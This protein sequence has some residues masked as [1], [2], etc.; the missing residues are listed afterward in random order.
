MTAPD[1][2]CAVV[3]AAGLGTRLR[4]LTTVL[5]KALAPVGNVPLLERALHRL[6]E[7]GLSGP[8]HVAVNAHH[9]ADK[10]ADL[11]GDRAHLSREPEPLGSAGALGL[12]KPW[13][14]DRAVL[15]LNA[16]AYVAAPAGDLR[17]LF[18]GWDGRTVRMLG[19][20]AEDGSPPFGGMSFAGASL[21]PPAEAAALNAEYSHLVLTTWRPAERTGRLQAIPLAGTYIDCGSPAAYL[22][23]N[24]HAAHGQNLVAPGAIVTGLALESVIGAGSRMNGTVRRC[25]LWPGAQ[26]DADELLIDSIRVGRDMTVEVTDA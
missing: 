19:R 22:A 11:V 13:I 18:D 6:S 25:V 23:A 21:I 26:V 24:M 4:P 15:V 14:G 5:P 8:R 12:L 7:V 2:V 9:M 20:H 1:D 17:A 10:I 16:D 3:L